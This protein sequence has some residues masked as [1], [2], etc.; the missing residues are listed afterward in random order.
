L[1]LMS[2]SMTKGVCAYGSSS[3]LTAPSHSIH[4]LLAR[5]S[6]HVHAPFTAHSHLIH[7]LFTPAFRH[8]RCDLDP[9]RLS[10]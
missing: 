2:I 10:P 6:H 4:T 9:L 7:T 5:T 1:P 3:H 8:G